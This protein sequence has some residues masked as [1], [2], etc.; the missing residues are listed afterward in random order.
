[1]RPH[2]TLSC[3]VLSCAPLILRARPLR[4]RGTPVQ[5]DARSQPA[6]H[7]LSLRLGLRE[8]QARVQ[9]VAPAAPAPYVH[10]APVPQPLSSTARGARVAG[11]PRTQIGWAFTTCGCSCLV[12]LVPPPQTHE[13]R[14]FYAQM[15][16]GERYRPRHLPVLYD[17]EPPQHRLPQ[18][19]ILG[20]STSALSSLVALPLTF[21]T[22]PVRAAH[23]ARVRCLPGAAQLRSLAALA[24]DD[25]GGLAEGH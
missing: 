5:C 22:A 17:C 19:C 16:L 11:C 18:P 24:D 13:P 12:C 23:F 15:V 20:D 21:G 25:R 3:C 1:M 10:P 9:Q 6:L 7:G 14:G 4:S 2:H 8:Y